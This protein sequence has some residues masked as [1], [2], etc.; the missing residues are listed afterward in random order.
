V[1]HY[2]TDEEFAQSPEA[3]LMRAAEERDEQLV[4]EAAERA[5]QGLALKLQEVI[6]LRVLKGATIGETAALL[7]LTEDQVRYATKLACELL[8]DA[9]A[10]AG[11]L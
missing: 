8:R 2:P 4:E 6:E 9:L 7:N 11:V 10:A 5:L 3:M 1:S